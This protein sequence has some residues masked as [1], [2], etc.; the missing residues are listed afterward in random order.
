MTIKPTARP[1]TATAN[2]YITI[3]APLASQYLDGELDIE[4]A[5]E[6]ES[7][8]PET[9]K[10]HL[11]EAGRYHGVT[12]RSRIVGNTVVFWLT[13]LIVRKGK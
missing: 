2:P 12:V 7:D 6:L 3:L 4:H 13:D 8:K 9:T 11:A 10:R 1:G 5:F